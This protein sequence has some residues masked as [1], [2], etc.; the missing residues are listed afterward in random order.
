MGDGPRSTE[1]VYNSASPQWARKEK[2]LLS[3]FTARPY[4]LDRLAPLSGLR[5][6]DLGC[7]EGYVARKIV[8][9]GAASVLGIDLSAGMIEQALAEAK[10]DGISGSD[11]TPYV[12]DTLHRLSAG[13]T[14]A[15][16]KALAVENAALAG[17]L[18]HALALPKVQ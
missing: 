9:A 18:A 17:R 1:E 15:C 8:D 3:D 16:N 2:L 10:R 14:V 5:V 7:G 4:V 12:L 6:L 13:R 11:V